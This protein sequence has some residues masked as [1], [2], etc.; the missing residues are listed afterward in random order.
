MSRAACRGVDPAVFFPTPTPSRW[1]RPPGAPSAAMCELES[2]AKA[3]CRECPVR[4]ECL[5]Y[6]LDHR[7]HDGVWGGLSARERRRLLQARPAE[8]G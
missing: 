1:S 3:V 6:A 8:A 7:E 4:D 2:L 5:A